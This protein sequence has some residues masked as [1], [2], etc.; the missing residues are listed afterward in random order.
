MLCR[1]ALRQWAKL[2][3]PCKNQTRLYPQLLS[4]SFHS[5]NHKYFAAECLQLSGTIFQG[6]H[7]LTGLPWYLSIPLTASLLR[8]TWIPVQ[9]LTHRTRKRRETA[10]QLA[11]AWRIAY[12]DTARIKFPG[13]QETDAKRAERWV[14]SQLKA[15]RKAIQKHISYLP[16]W[17][18]PLLAISFIPVWVFSMDCIRRMAGDKRT[19]TSL[20]FKSSDGSTIDPNIVPMEPGFQTESL[21][22]IPDLAA[23]D[24]LWILPITYGALATVSVWL[25]VREA[26]RLQP[27]DNHPP[28]R[29]G[30]DEMLKAAAAKFNRGLSYVLT[31][32]PTVFTYLIIRSDLSTAVVLYLIGTTTTQ[33]VQR[34]LLARVLGTSKRFPLLKAKQ[35]KTKGQVEE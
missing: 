22:W 35:A 13:G 26:A 24:H 31:A 29:T 28:L 12:Q 11:S 32:M 34:P 2:E 4:R 18:E 30:R 33:L 23:P 17:T 7:T 20:F 9:L 1:R 5:T 15:R 21:W 14:S 16:V 10:M 25:R 3:A 8:M 19:V 27:D 6:V